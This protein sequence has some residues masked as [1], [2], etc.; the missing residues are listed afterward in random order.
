[1]PL[2]NCPINL[3]LTWSEKFVLADNITHAV[4]A[5]QRDN[6]TRPAIRAPTNA[7][8]KITDTELSVPVVTLWTEDGHKMFE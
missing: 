7:T 8:F 6:P 5:A 3:L 2:E 1:M 4:L